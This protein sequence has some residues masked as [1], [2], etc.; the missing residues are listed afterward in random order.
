MQIDHGIDLFGRRALKAIKSRRGQIA[1][2]IFCLLS[3]TD[4]VWDAPATMRIHEGIETAGFFLMIIAILGRS[5]CAIYA[6]NGDQLH[7]NEY[8]PYSVCR[9]PSELFVILGAA[10]AGAQFGTIS[11]TLVLAIVMAFYSAVTVRGKERAL[12]GKFGRAYDEYCAGVPRFVPALRSWKTSHRTQT[13]PA[14]VVRT[15]LVTS[16][17]LAAWPV[18]EI[19]EILQNQGHLSSLWFLP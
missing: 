11:T 5:W 6:G 7:L 10:G 8:G 2:V 1:L 17:T 9:N 15:F 12:R 14:F 18:A 19:I 3:F 4:S 13:S 16:T